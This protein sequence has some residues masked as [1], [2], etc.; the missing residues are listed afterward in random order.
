M[1]FVYVHF[2]FNRSLFILHLCCRVL[3][4]GAGLTLFIMVPRFDSQYQITLT[5]CVEQKSDFSFVTL[6]TSP[7]RLVTSNWLRSHPNRL[8]PIHLGSTLHR[9]S[10]KLQAAT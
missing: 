9:A 3:I 7:N 4:S 8:R 6:P 10:L 5:Q 1:N 2:I